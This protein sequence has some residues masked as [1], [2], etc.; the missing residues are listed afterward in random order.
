M[1]T[2][3][4]IAVVLDGDFKVAQYSQWDNYPSGNG[5]N[6]LNFM[7]EMM[8]GKRSIEKFRKNLRACTW[9]D[10]AELSAMWKAAGAK[11]DGMIDYDAAKKFGAEHP[12]FSRDTGAKILALVYKQ[13]LKLQDQ[14]EFAGDGL[15]CEWAY[16]IDL[17]QEQFEVYEGFKQY[18]MPEGQR[19]SNFK[20]NHNEY[21]PV[22]L[23]HLWKLNELP[24]K[25]TFLKTLEP[26]EDAEDAGEAA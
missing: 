8:R 10:E 17:D 4:L 19:F 21:T 9:I 5:V 11:D 16:V 7:Q 1:G 20:S 18:T 13:P 26:Q 14:K 25:R 23:K 12:E 2:R 22:Q 3:G 6:I 24:N 15:F